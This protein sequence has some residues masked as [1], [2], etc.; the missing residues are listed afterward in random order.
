MVDEW[1]LQDGRVVD[2]FLSKSGNSASLRALPA[3]LV[4]VTSEALPTLPALN[5]GSS[6]LSSAAERAAERKCLCGETGW[7]VCIPDLFLH[8]FLVLLGIVLTLHKVALSCE[9][10]LRLVIS[11]FCLPQVRLSSRK[12]V[13]SAASLRLGRPAQATAG[14]LVPASSIGLAVPAGSLLVSDCVRRAR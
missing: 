3:V 10:R 9:D 8:F 13:R 14:R 1:V 5:D 4:W 2:V 11:V 6:G 12:S 7:S